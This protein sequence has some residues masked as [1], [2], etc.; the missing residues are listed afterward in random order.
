[1]DAGGRR[2]GDSFCAGYLER[3]HGKDDY[4]AATVHVRVWQRL[5]RDCGGTGTLN[6]MLFSCWLRFAACD[7]CWLAVALQLG[8][9]SVV[10]S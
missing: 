8:Q 7:S 1:M 6:L 2:Q 4:R 5:R 9:C 10:N 3:V